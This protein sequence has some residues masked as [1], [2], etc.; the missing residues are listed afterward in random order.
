MHPRAVQG[1]HSKWHIPITTNLLNSLYRGY[2][3]FFIMDPSN[4]LTKPMDLFS[5]YLKMHKIKFRELQGKPTYRNTALSLEPESPRLRILTIAKILSVQA[6]KLTYPL[7]PSS[8]RIT[9][10]PHKLYQIVCF[11]HYLFLD[12]WLQ[13]GLGDRPK[14]KSPSQA[15]WLWMFI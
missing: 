9:Q 12:L 11:F 2:N 6:P 4:S 1:L 8:N 3:S 7:I 14:Y 13:A 10:P 5:E 15:S